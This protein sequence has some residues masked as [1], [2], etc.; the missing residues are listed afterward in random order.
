MFALVGHTKCFCCE[1][2]GYVAKQYHHPNKKLSGVA[3]LSLQ[4]PHLF[5]LRP[6]SISILPTPKMYCSPTMW[7]V[8]TRLYFYKE[9]LAPER[10]KKL[11]IAYNRLQ[12]SIGFN[13]L[14][15]YFL[16]ILVLAGFLLVISQFQRLHVFV[17]PQLE[18]RT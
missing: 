18:I 14:N 10:S 8:V 9:V 16:T 2:I 7:Y 15:C 17:Y 12:I 3:N 4:K 5:I 13:T 6:V 11:L 1:F